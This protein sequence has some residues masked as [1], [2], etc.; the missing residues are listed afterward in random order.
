MYVGA[1]PPWVMRRAVLTLLAVAELVPAWAI[2]AASMSD[3]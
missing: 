2:L 1:Q 3:N